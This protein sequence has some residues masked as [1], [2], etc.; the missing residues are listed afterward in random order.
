MTIVRKHPKVPSSGHGR[1]R[2][3]LSASRL[4]ASSSSTNCSFYSNNVLNLRPL[5]ESGVSSYS[6]PSAA[7]SRFLPFHPASGIGRDGKAEDKII[8]HLSLVE[9]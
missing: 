1:F 2:P 8:P 9:L 5:R 7:A 6:S 3:S 4:K